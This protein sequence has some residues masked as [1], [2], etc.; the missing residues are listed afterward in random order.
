LNEGPQNRHG[1][2]QRLTLLLFLVGWVAS[3]VALIFV[4]KAIIPEANLEADL[5]AI[6]AVDTDPA[7]LDGALPP[8]LQ[9]LSGLRR[10]LPLSGSV[11]VPLYDT[12]YVGGQRSLKNLS[13]TLSLRNTSSDQTLVV[14]S[15]TYFDSKG[16]IIAELLK[17]PHSMA[18]MTTAEVYIDQS[19]A[20]DT[21]IAGVVV[22]WGA[23]TSIAPPLAEAVIVG[24]Y[25]A[26]SISF[27]SRGE[28][29]P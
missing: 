7:A 28:R 1:S 23:E 2:S 9:P 26:K 15:V 22:G 16:A 17:S 11:Y 24:S 5:A 13:A 20:D 8:E 14:T 29:R 19:R 25:G 3:I 12:L 4:M 18:P 10:E 21:S 6:E 27:V